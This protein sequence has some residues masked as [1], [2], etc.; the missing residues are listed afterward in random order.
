M[1]HNSVV[2]LGLRLGC[3]V[4]VVSLGEAGLLAASFCYLGGEAELCFFFRL[5]RFAALGRFRG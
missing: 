3:L 1:L 5:N 4:S 2:R